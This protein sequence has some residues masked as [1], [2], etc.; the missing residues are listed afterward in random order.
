MTPM[1][2]ARKRLGL[3]IYDV[4]EKTGLR[5]GSVSRIERGYSA[6]PAAAEKISQAL[7][8]LTE[9]MIL[10]PARF[11]QLTDDPDQRKAA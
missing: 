6:S 8:G 10:Y 7:P 5:A 9:E 4:A 2:C 1:K 11:P 3:T